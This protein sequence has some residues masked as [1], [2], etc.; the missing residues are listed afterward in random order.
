M[1]QEEPLEKFGQFITEKLR[2]NQFRF[3]EDVLAGKYKSQRLIDLHE[4]LLL[5]NEKQKSIALNFVKTVVD[6]GIHDFLFAIVERA[7]FEGD[8]NILVDGE[9]V[10]QLSDGIHGEA[11]GE[12]GWNAKFS[13][14]GD[15]E[16]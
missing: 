12:D 7:D 8:L 11:Y 5:L 14:Y 4:Q 1:S 9:D 10:V 16:Y 15:V 2:D 6:T 3:A 13:K